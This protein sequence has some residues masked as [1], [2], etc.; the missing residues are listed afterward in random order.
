[1]VVAWLSPVVFLV[2]S[3]WPVGNAMPAVML[4]LLA[5]IVM[6]SRA[7]D[8]ADPVAVMEM[9]GKDRA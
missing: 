7:A 8:V 6:R 1:M 9:H 2:P 3:T 4:A 5:V